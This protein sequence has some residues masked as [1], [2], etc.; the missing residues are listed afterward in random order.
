MKKIYSIVIMLIAL[1]NAT[2]L[3]AQT[4]YYSKA[5]GN[6]NQTTTWGINA[7]GTGTAPSG[8]TTS[9]DLFILRSASTLSINGNWTI[10]AG[11]TLQLDGVLNVSSNND[12]ITVNGTIIFTAVNSTQITLTG[13]GN[14]NDFTLSANATLKTANVNGIRGTNASLPTTISG[15]SSIILNSGANYHFTGNANQATTGMPATVSSLT[16]N[17][18]GAG[19]SNIVTLSQAT[20]VTSTLDL[21]NGVLNTNTN[22]LTLNAGS[23]VAGSS[24]TSFVDGPLKKFGNTAFTFPVGK[25]GNGIHPI[26]I[27]APASSTDAF[28]ATYF[29]QPWNIRGTL[30]SPLTALGNCEHWRLNRD[31]GTSNV[32]VTI[33]WN[34]D[35][36]CGNA[37][38][39]TLS[40]LTVGYSSGSGSWGLAAGTGTN[41][42]GTTTAGSVERVGVSNFGYFALGSLIAGGS[43]LPV[44]YDGV[45]AYAKN[46]GAQIEWSNLTERD[47]KSYKVERSS[48]GIDYTEIAAYEPKSNRND[49]ASY[50]HFDASP[51][52]GANYYRIHAIEIDGKNIFSKILR[53][54]MNGAVSLNL[55]PNPV[56]GRQMTIS[57]TGMKEGNYNVR[58][59][60]ASGQDVFKKQLLNKSSS[61]SE[62]IELPASAKSGVYTM[63]ISSDNF[64][65]SRM[66]IIK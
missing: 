26:S 52:A 62:M 31:A 16:I 63:L 19:G 43:P 34:A 12:D 46:N 53:V 25:S 49:K 22:L 29:R 36:P 56:T 59:I 32:N 51:L 39:T 55:Y 58:I 37:Y 61:T 10:G 64:N 24:A 18:T 15:N 35:S 57:L 65:T 66:F 41:I 3:L 4:T 30:G 48:N 28:T 47:I 8:F 17:N 7:D 14:G 11:V 1:L 20:T 13:G 5:S 44:M 38:V 2:A 27:S 60:N 9:S 45:K 54:E 40:G 50:T 21:T 23:V 33:T 6:A 42:S